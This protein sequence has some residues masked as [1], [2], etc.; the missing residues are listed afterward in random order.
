MMITDWSDG[1]GGPDGGGDGGGGGGGP[2]A[3]GP[4]AEL[5]RHRH[6]THTV[7]DAA[8]RFRASRACLKLIGTR[9]DW[10]VNLECVVLGMRLNVRFGLRTTIAMSCSGLIERPAEYI[11]EKVVQR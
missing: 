5:E 11:H 3:A 8:E 10:G 6:G 1:Y 9:T 2:V 7:G 4:P